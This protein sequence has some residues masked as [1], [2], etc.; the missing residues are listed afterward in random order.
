MKKENEIRKFLGE[1]Y[2][3]CVEIFADGQPVVWR[4]YKRYKNIDPIFW[5]KDN[6]AIM[7]SEFNTEEELYDFAKS[8]RR[9]NWPMISRKVRMTI[10]LS[11]LALSIVNAIFL[12]IETIS[13][14]ILS[15]DFILL[16]WALLDFWSA[17][18]NMKVDILEL[19]DNSAR[20]KKWIAEEEKKS[21]A[22]KEDETK[23]IYNM[24]KEFH[25]EKNGVKETIS[26]LTYVI[27][28]LKKKLKIEGEVK[29]VKKR[30]RKKKEETKKDA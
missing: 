29:N 21:E 10:L 17:D 18:N 3:L 24:L 4:L 22:V 5:S 15:C 2:H 6:K 28:E 26:F 11:L 14:F 1:D 8:H 19:E 9:F 16:I 13:I 12:R 7:S 27:E 30:G 25:Y 20:F 23:R